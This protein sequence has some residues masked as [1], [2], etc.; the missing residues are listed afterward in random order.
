MTAPTF[1]E[2]LTLARQLF[3]KTE[4]EFDHSLAVGKRDT[5]SAITALTSAAYQLT[6][7]HLPEVSGNTKVA[8][9]IQRQDNARALIDATMPEREALIAAARAKRYAG[10]SV[11]SAGPVRYAESDPS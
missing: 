4:A 9:L 10:W 3:G 1:A 6:N 7:I 2:L 5:S 8:D 11:H